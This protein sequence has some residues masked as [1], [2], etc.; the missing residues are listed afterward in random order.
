MILDIFSMIVPH[1]CG[2]SEHLG[3]REELLFNE[4]THIK[5]VQTSLLSQSQLVQDV[6]HGTSFAEPSK[7]RFKR[8][9]LL[10]HKSA[11]PH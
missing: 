4:K 9:L 10:S 1:L 2:Q 3:L 11:P 7:V 5:I 8:H 6:L